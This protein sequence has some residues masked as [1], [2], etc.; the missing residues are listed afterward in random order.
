[1]NNNI[2]S[3]IKERKELKS[4][5]GYGDI[6]KIAALADIERTTVHRWFRGE[7]DNPD[8]A[9]AVEGL[10]ALKMQIVTDRLKSLAKKK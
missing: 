3:K 9:L 6:V 5:L 10:I 1:M 2:E 4:K 8:I 7:T